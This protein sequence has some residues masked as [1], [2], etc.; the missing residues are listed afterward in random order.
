MGD[1]IVPAAVEHLTNGWEPDVPPDDTLKRRAVLVHARWPVAVA[2][3]LGA[4][5]RSTDRW[6]G[7]VIG[8]VGALLGLVLLGLGAELLKPRLGG[9]KLR[10]EIA[11]EGAQALGDGVD[12]LTQPLKLG[13]RKVAPVERGFPLIEV[14]LG[15]IELRPQGLGF[16]RE[17]RRRSRRRGRVAGV[18]PSGLIR[19]LGLALSG[20]VRSLGKSGRRQRAG[21][22]DQHKRATGD[23]ERSTEAFEETR[24]HADLFYP[25]LGSAS[26]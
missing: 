12:P 11:D 6:S 13:T 2:T 8:E 5:Y 23:N 3:A 26:V 15:S 24:H 18:G 9:L 22:C 16:G 14:E 1:S 19:L 7:A 25:N 17:R 21:G 10:R 20:D 4:P